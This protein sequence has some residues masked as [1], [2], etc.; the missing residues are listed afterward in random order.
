MTTGQLTSLISK[1][2]AMNNE[3][4]RKISSFI[5]AVVGDAACVHLEWVYDQAKVAEIVGEKD[6]AFWPESHVP[7]FTLPNGK[8]S[9]YAD[10]AVQSLNAMAENDGKY[11]SDKLIQHFLHYFGD[12]ESPYQIAKAKRADKKYPIEGNTNKYL[13]NSLNMYLLTYAVCIYF[14][15]MKDIDDNCPSQ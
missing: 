8:V 14:K 6:P 7:F 5:G 4:S 11:D 15:I 2:S 9:C 12:P 13:L 10:E 3:T 1:V